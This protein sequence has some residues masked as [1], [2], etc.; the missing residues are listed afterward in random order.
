M[1]P[2]H[3]DSYSKIYRLRIWTLQIFSC[4]C[5]CSPRIQKYGIS[6]AQWILKNRLKL[7]GLKEELIASFLNV[8]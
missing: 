3:A 6:G 4:A 8:K 2:V 1:A 7:S 5:L